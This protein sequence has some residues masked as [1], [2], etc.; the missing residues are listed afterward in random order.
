VHGLGRVVCCRAQVKDSS[1]RSLGFLM[2][3]LPIVGL[4]LAGLAAAVLG[5]GPA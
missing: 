2:S 5:K 1:G 3:F 4:A